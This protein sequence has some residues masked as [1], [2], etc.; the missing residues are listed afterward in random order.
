M[1]THY[2][3]LNQ[4]VLNKGK[5]DKFRV[6]LNIP[7][8]LQSINQPDQ[9]KNELISLNKLQFSPINISIPGTTISPIAIPFGGQSPHVTSQTRD[10]YTQVKIDFKVDNNYDNYHLLWAWLNV[11]NQHHDSGMDPHFDQLKMSNSK[12]VSFGA[13]N[14]DTSSTIQYKHIEHKNSFVDYQTPITVFGLREYNE[15]IIKFT[16]SGAFIT[17]LGDLVYDFK[18]AGELACSFSFS[19]SQL[20]I[21]LLTVIPHTSNTIIQP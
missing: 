8:I 3:D 6:V 19:F 20:D 2:T 9:R 11:I 16:Y 12:K 7:P 5:Q 21:E 17:T 10:P 13:E 15:P 1:S 4:S 18:E 14:G